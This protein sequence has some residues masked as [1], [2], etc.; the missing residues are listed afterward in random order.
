MNLNQFG[1]ENVQFICLWPL[2]GMDPAGP[3]F[4]MPWDRGA[5]HR[6]SDIDAQ[7]VQCIQTASG[8][9]GTHKDCGRGS[10][11]FI[12][13]GGIK[14]PG[15][16]TVFCSHSRA[17]AYFNEAMLE[18]HIFAGKKCTGRIHYFL[19]KVLGMHCSMESEQLG[20]HA[21]GKPG[22]FFIKTNAAPPFAK[23][24]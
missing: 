4:T 18:G 20:I 14:Q 24:T 5:G 10:A 9:L 23:N 12:I 11:T 15:C 13:N 16:L 17:H 2:I 1:F 7:Y 6:L 3:G 19:S 22:R 8:T 21:E